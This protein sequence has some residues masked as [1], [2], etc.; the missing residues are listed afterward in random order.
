MS[1]RELFK[2][3]GLPV[4]QNKMFADRAAALGCPKGDVRLVQDMDTGLIYNASFD[5]SLLEY[6]ADYQNEQACSG[7][8]QRHLEDVKVIIQRHFSGKPLIE[9]GCGKGYFLE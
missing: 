8:F 9:V 6:D 1:Y 3:K 5:A 2:V 4:F 7:V